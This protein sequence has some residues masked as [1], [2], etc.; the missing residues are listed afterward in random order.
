MSMAYVVGHITVKDEARWAEY[1]AR[2]PGTLEP[3]GAELVCRGHQVAVWAGENPHSDLVV[4]RFASVE[5][6]DGWFHSP[7]YQALIP[8]RQQAAEVVLL[9]YEE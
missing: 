2:V 9:C 7:A 4:I 6:A 5:A 3:W 1:R 8:L